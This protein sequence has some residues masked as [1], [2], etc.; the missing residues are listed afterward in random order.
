MTITNDDNDVLITLVASLL[1]PGNAVSQEDILDALVECSGDV[2]KAAKH[3]T[4]APSSSTATGQVRAGT[5]STL[6]RKRKSNLDAWLNPHSSPS[7]RSGSRSEPVEPPVQKLRLEPAKVKSA[8]SSKPVKDLM[9]VLRPPP[10]TEKKGPPKLPPLML[11]SPSLVAEHTPCTLHTSVLPQELACELFYTMLDLSQS[12]KRNK[13][14]LFD[15]VVES[16]HLTSFFAR[17]T[18]GLDDDVDWQEAAQYW[19][20]GRPTDPPSVFPEPM[21]RACRIVERIV[22]E[23]LKTR[24]RFGLE[25]GVN[26]SAPEWRANVAASNCYQGGKESVGWHSDQLTYLGPYPTIAS[27]SLGEPWNVG[28]WSRGAKAKRTSF[29]ADP[30]TRRNF[31]LREVIPT[32]EAD[33][34]RARTFNVPLPHNSLTIMH[35]SCQERFKHSIPPQSSIDMYRPAFPRRSE[36]TKPNAAISGDSPA[37]CASTS[38]SSAATSTA[39]EPSNCRINITFRFYRPDFRPGTIP[40]CHC[41]VPT[42][43]RPDMKNRTDG[44]TDKYWWACYAGAQNDGKG[45]NF[46]KVLDMEKEGRGP[47]VG[48]T[49]GP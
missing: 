40:K 31:S 45:C 19:Y 18:N 7:T 13:W 23:E 8:S 17:R 38:T 30:G 29:I 46:W 9:T 3:L 20:N 1:D 37:A 16:P 2:E 14:W 15:R 42:I 28:E 33:S 5:S 11:S 34:R 12:W 27:L 48:D 21:E 22:N 43:L 32:Q 39:I 44:R 49:K 25:W 4:N 6:K 47:C 41:G 26:G 24:K 36:S 10:S 35:A